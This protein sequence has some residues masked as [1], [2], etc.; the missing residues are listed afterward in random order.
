[1][2]LAFHPSL[3]LGIL[4]VLPLL[5]LTVSEGLELFEFLCEFLRIGLGEQ[6]PRDVE[7]RFV[8]MVKAS[9]NPLSRA[10][11][12]RD[13]VVPPRVPLPFEP[14]NDNHSFIS[15]VIPAILNRCCNSCTCWKASVIPAVRRQ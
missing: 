1:M 5:G 8:P 13:E 14:I 4:K 9:H 12:H 2:A 10:C 6:P 15:L 7:G 3:H 11:F